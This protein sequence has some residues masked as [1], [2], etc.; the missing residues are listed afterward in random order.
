MYHLRLLSAC[1]ILTFVAADAR[2]QAC[3]EPPRNPQIMQIRADGG[4][5]QFV[6]NRCPGVS[7]SRN[8]DLCSS[9]GERPEIQFILTGSAASDWRFV[10][11]ELSSNGSDWG[12]PALPAGVLADFDF[13]SASDQAR[14]IPSA[15]VDGNRMIVANDNCN[16][17]EVHY[18]LV[19]SGPDGEA[20]LHPIIRNG[21][22]GGM[23]N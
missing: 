20:I 23:G 18:R 6:D 13:A 7:G 4:A 11:M 10:R 19:L 5:P 9:A 22:T 21:G 3:K 2:A 1:V 14:G 8:G 17:F 12:A 15:R 16:R